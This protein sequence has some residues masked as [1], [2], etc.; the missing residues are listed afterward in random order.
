MESEYVLKQ[1]IGWY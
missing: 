1:V